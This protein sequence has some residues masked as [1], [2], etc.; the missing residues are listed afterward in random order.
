[1]THAEFRALA[2]A[3]IR[4]QMQTGIADITL[5]S[6]GRRPGRAGQVSVS[7][8]DGQRTVPEIA[9]LMH[10]FQ[11]NGIDVYV[12]SAGFEPLVEAIASSPAF[13]YNLPA[14]KVYGLRLEEEPDGT[15]KPEYRHGYPVTFGPASRR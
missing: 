4:H 14:D 6:P 11:A 3:S 13:G 10:T 7:Y 8:T 15:Y 5:T 1:M 2:V 12:V 9:N